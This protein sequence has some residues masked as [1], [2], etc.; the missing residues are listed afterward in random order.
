VTRKVYTFV[1]L[2]QWTKPWTDEDLYA[3]YDL[4]AEEIEFVEKLVRRM[5]LATDPGAE[6]ASSDD[7]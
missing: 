3:R 7:E 5:D 6:A 1:P 4:S 2:Q